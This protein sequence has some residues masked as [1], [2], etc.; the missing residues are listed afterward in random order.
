MPI[1]RRS[2]STMTRLLAC[3]RAAVAVALLRGIVASPAAPESG[4]SDAALHR[5]FQ[6]A[7]ARIATNAF[8]GIVSRADWER[9]RE[10]RRREL[11]D[12][13]G[14]WPL[15]PRADL[16]ATVTGRI[17]L[18]EVVVEKLQFQALPGLYV[19]ANF[20]L[21]RE[22]PHP[23]PAILYACGH[24][25][26]KTNGVSLG[27]KTFYQ[28]HG[29]WFAEH[30]YVCLVIDT[31]Q[32]GEIQGDHHG[33]YRLGQWWWNSRGYTPAGVEA[34]DCI[35]AID[36]L[37]TRPEV[38]RSRIGMTGRSGGGSYT[39]TTAAVD[40]RIRVAAPVAG[41]TDLHNHV[42]D[43]TVEGHCDCMFFVN[44]YRWDFGLNAALIAPRPLLIVNTDADTLFPL[45]GVVRVHN[46][47]LKIYRLYGVETNLGL[48]IGPGP[49]RDT[50]DLQVPVFRWFNHFLKGADPLVTDAARKRIDPADLRVFTG[51]PS[52]ERNTRAQE[53][54]GP[55]AAGPGPAPDSD[56]ILS[57]LR[58][59]TFGAW[60]ET[61]PPL[62]PRALVDVTL[63]TA[64][65]RA[66]DFESE[67]EVPLRLYALSGD[68]RTTAGLLRIL[69]PPAWERLRSF[70]DR[71]PG[72]AQDWRP[73]LPGPNHAL[74]WLAPRG[75]GPEAWS[76]D[77]RKQIQI[78]RRFM[79]LGST[80]DSMRVW[81]IQRGVDLMRRVMP[82]LKEVE[83]AADGSMAV[84]AL[85]ASLFQPG[86]QSL[87]L[88]DCPA[89]MRDGPDYLNVLQALNLSQALKLAR[90][91]GVRITMEGRE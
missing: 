8:A 61:P 84:N 70:L 26:V 4:Q 21:P 53:W 39:W 91:K 16:R 74:A 47:A 12:M 87:R 17:E 73:G 32:L 25:E 88:R 5:Y 37:E 22:V 62:Q 57:P 34:W 51:L 80:V 72:S 46:Q 11:L 55:P 42:I 23:L 43:G 85:F 65:L 64:R 82:D 44:T 40:D 76:G 13:L 2:L 14:L 79:L 27:N 29:L 28:H 50:Q 3:P 81:D 56:A 18:K 49:H 69:D 31:L 90:D 54:F 24:A 41:I 52:D 66:W 7:T 83:I 67:P 68:D 75:V 10:E 36:Y 9:Q 45:D 58:Q 63:G 33:T 78:R 48:V 89:S 38:D 15:P 77:A 6:S 86:I 20:Y 19:T 30:G 71:T 60:P 1:D 35:R 59:R